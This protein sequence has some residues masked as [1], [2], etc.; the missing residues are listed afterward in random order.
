MAFVT[1]FLATLTGV[2]VG[3]TLVYLFQRYVV[4]LYDEA[5]D[6][7]LYNIRVLK[8]KRRRR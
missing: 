5:H 6:E 1:D 8:E 3:Q 7:L 4:P 2:I